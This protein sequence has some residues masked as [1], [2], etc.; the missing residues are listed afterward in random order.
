MIRTELRNAELT[1]LV[2]L[3]RTQQDIKYD[4]VASSDSLFYS[5]EGNLM[6]EGGDIEIT[7]EGVTST[8][9]TLTPTRIFE[10][11]VSQKLGIPRR[12]IT[13]MRDQGQG[14]LLTDNVNTWLHHGEMADKNWFIRG[15]YHDGN[16]IARAM[17][18]DR[19]QVIDHLDTL[20]AALDG[21]RRADT[22]TSIGKCNLTERSMYVEVEAPAIQAM[23]PILLADY[24]SPFTGQRG[25]DNPVVFAGFVLSNSETGSGAFTI[26]PRITIQVC[27]NG[28]QYNVEAMRRVHLGSKMTEGEIAWSEETRY[29]Y[30]ELIK[31]Q[32]TDAV[33][34]FLSIDYLTR[35]VATL[36]EQ[37]TVRLSSPRRAIEN[38]SKELKYSDEEA[39]AIF[40][41]FIAGGDNR[42]IGVLQAVTAYAQVVD[43]ADRA[44]ELEGD[45][46]R[47]LEL[48]VRYA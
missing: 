47:A 26:T 3:L 23:A 7:T 14:P 13:R 22:P 38:V 6:V 1:D 44:N 37:G 11:H 8:V 48:A 41:L 40:D 10:D 12:Y 20:T 39:D 35:K 36:E 9:A 24:R 31:H 42:A 19:Y 32:V 5:P 21:I 25:A 45:G 4:I 28:L 33:S 18:S 34:T 43:D 2:T 16:G 29:H 27:R 30:F 46:V 15:F 17:L